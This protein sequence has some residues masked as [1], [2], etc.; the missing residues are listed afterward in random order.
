M[1]DTRT[2]V[3]FERITTVLSAWMVFGVY[4]DGWGHHHGAAE[5]FLTPWHF[6]LY[7]GYAVLGAT[8]WG[9]W[10]RRRR[11]GLTPAVPP[12]YKLA[13]IGAAVFFAGG[14]ADGVWH[15]IFGIE[16][17]VEAFV[18]PPHMTLFISGVLM[19]LGPVYSTRYRVQ[20]M[21]TWREAWPAVFSIA[22]A[23]GLTQFATENDNALLLP[24]PAGEQ[25][26]YAGPL[27]PH[28]FLPF[29]IGVGWGLSAVMVQSVMIAAF[30]VVLVSRMRPP[31]GSVTVIMLIGVGHSLIIHNAFWLLLAV[32]AAGLVG[33]LLTAAVFAGRR[34]LWML[35]GA[36]TASLTTGWLI[37]NAVQ[38][39]LVW[40]T[41]LITGAVCTA[42]VAGVG[43]GVIAA[44]RAYHRRPSSVP[45][46]EVTP[47]VRAL[48]PTS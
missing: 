20:T 23:V 41:H 35:T 26:P 17:K 3:R 5:S 43:I 10:L 34:P 22:F 44:S 13:M 32:T 16:H 37:V 25:L 31:F 36:V 39:G 33:D 46:D 14:V 7:S 6:L 9:Y 27:G 30:L 15:N 38:N 18:S 2:R 48:A 45:S 8:M 24:A 29:E 4:L 19:V 28:G 11:Q 12:G 42:G 40:S 47:A 21:S 1:I